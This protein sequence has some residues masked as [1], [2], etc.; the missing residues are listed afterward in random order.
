[1][2]TQSQYLRALIRE[3]ERGKFSLLLAVK[4]YP[5][6]DDD[7]PVD[8]AL[9]VGEVII[10]SIERLTPRQMI[11]LFPL[12]KE[13]DGERYGCKDYF[14]ARKSVEEYGLD[15]RIENAVDFLWDYQND[16][17]ARFMVEYLCFA[18]KRYRQ[19]TGRNMAQDGLEAAHIPYQAITGDGL[20][21]THFDGDTRVEVP[22]LPVWREKGL[23]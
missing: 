1:M 23:I 4:G 15:R 17:L 21:L 7:V 14:Y 11:N 9:T 16:D 18:G 19:Q 20:Y 2:P 5:N 12:K 13:F 10:R 22:N 3:G 8:A 6:S